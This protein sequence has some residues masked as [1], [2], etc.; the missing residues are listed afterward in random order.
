MYLTEAPPSLFAE[1]QALE[2][3]VK[4]DLLALNKKR[5]RLTELKEVRNAAIFQVIFKSYS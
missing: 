5:Q 3:E 4:A 2:E 1:A